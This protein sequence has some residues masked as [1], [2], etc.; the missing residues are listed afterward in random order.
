MCCSEFCSAC[1]GEGSK[2][3]DLFSFFDVYTHN[4]HIFNRKFF[5]K[6]KKYW[7]NKKNDPYLFNVN[8]LESLDI[9]TEEEFS[10]IE[11][12]YKSLKLANLL[13]I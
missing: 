8:F 4:F 7:S 12:I 11:T 6:N 2:S 5:I 13:E 3:N 9:D 10:A 1:T